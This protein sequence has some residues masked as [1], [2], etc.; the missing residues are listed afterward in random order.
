M[1]HHKF[2][3]PNVHNVVLFGKSVSRGSKCKAIVKADRPSIPC[4]TTPSTT[5][6]LVPSKY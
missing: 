4:Q 3:G 6:E 1:E 5:P 2:H